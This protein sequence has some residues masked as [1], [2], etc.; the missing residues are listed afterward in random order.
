MEDVPYSKQYPD[1]QDWDDPPTCIIWEDFRR[2]LQHVRTT[3]KLPEHH[4]SHDHLNKQVVVGIEDDV[5]RQW[6]EAFERYEAAQRAEGVEVVW[7]IVD[8]FVLYWDKV[9]RVPFLPRGRGE[10]G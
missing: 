9:G 2:C 5:L 7:F 8:G 3:G 10:R 1:V 6:R 4:S